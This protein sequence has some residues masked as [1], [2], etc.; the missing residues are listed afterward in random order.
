MDAVEPAAPPSSASLGRRFA[1]GAFWSLVGTAV[2]QAC[3]MAGSIVTARILGA[4]PYGQL[5]IVM[6]T[7]GAFGVVAS[8]GMGLTATRFVS[9]YRERD[10]DR[11]GRVLGLALLST[12]LAASVAALA[13]L[14]ASPTIADQSLHAPHLARE[15]RVACLSLLLSAVAGT[16]TGGLTGLEAFR[17]VAAVSLAQALV[18]LPLRVA[19]AM[20]FGVSGAVWALAA[21]P[22]VAVALSAFALRRACR[23]RSVPVRLRGLGAEMPVLWRFSLPAL[24]SGAL[25][26]PAQWLA[27]TILVGL[28]N[29]FAELGVLNAATQWRTLLVFLPTVLAG[30]ALPLMSSGLTDTE[31]TDGRDCARTFEMT[32]GLSILVVFP[33]GALAAFL[34]GPI[35][36]LYGRTY[37]GGDVML[38][39]TVATAM[40]ATVG[41]AVGTAVQARGRM[42]LGFSTSLSWAA[43]LVAATLLGAGR[44][45]G[46]SIAFGGALAHVQ[47]GVWPFLLL[48]RSFPRATLLR[49]LGQMAVCVALPAAALL[50]PAAD[51]L[52]LALPAGLAVS[53]AS[54][55]LLC[56]PEVRE[57]ALG[58]LRERSRRR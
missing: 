1:R 58:L 47:A 14:L 56:A 18:G 41:V 24:L 40:A 20:W 8:F 4:D 3:Q 13:M 34:T 28:P 19:G 51:R 27:N 11:A 30:V 36:A 2:G 6:S 43:C 7:A 25:T 22:G 45:G 23:A 42:W 39:G 31:E 50:T 54:W 38:I 48:R 15:L 32:Q 44:W 33:L 49:L 57:R 17:A 29:G 26:M 46:A 52:W 35:L 5:G 53:A 12:V 55:W 37:E 16:L 9:Q 21:T 10:P